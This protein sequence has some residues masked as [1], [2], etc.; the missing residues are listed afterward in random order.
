MPV[1]WSVLMQETLETHPRS[2][3]VNTINLGLCGSRNSPLSIDLVVNIHGPYMLQSVKSS[4]DGGNFVLYTS[5]SWKG[6]NYRKA[7]G[8]PCPAFF[9]LCPFYVSCSH[10][11][12]SLPSSSLLF[13]SLSPSVLVLSPFFPLPPS[14]IFTLHASHLLHLFITPNKILNV[15]LLYLAPIFSYPRLLFLSFIPIFFSFLLSP[16]SLLSL[17]IPF[18]F[19]LFQALSNFLSFYLCLIYSLPII[20]LSFLL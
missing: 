7:V 12:L 20:Y 18:L 15:F 13:I 16:S 9:S 19:L 14:S 4:Q 3:E 10:S 6:V 17:D 11:V 2:L 1:V 8:N 5:S